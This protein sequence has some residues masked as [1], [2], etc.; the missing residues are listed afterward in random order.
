M[1]LDGIRRLV[2][3]VAECDQETAGGLQVLYA[4]AFGRDVGGLGESC[5]FGRKGPD[6]M[7]G[8]GLAD[9]NLEL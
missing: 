8:S 7:V 3:A 2:I 1:Q 9:E 4:D 5:D 6:A